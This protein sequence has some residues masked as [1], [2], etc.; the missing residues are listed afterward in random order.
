M[1]E[2]MFA[3]FIPLFLGAVALWIIHMVG[4]FIA[5]A[6]DWIRGLGDE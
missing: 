6:F 5:G 3:L 4:A 2:T 1:V